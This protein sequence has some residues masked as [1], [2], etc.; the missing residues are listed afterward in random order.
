MEPIS[1][2]RFVKPPPITPIGLNTLLS[3]FV[4]NGV[5]AYGARSEPVEPI[6]SPTLLKVRWNHW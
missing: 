4:F 5:E 1:A 6:V 2:T 3:H